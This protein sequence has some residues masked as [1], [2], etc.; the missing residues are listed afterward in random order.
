MTRLDLR[1]DGPHSDDYTAEVARACGETVRVLNHATFCRAGGLSHPQTVYT[2]ASGLSDAAMGM[3]QTLNQLAEFLE[4]E[5]LM[6]RLACDDGS[7]PQAMV[8]HARR[9]AERAKTAAYM[10]GTALGHMQTAVSRLYVP[11]GDQP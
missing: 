5:S 4:S 6:E 1:T 10:L 2:V 8:D 11:E 9:C 3:P 7:N